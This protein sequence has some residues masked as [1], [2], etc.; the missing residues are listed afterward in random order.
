MGSFGFPGELAT[1]IDAVPGLADELWQ[2]GDV[3]GTAGFLDAVQGAVDDGR[4]ALVVGHHIAVWNRLKEETPAYLL[5]YE[6]FAQ[7]HV[8]LWAE[9]GLEPPNR[10]AF[11]GFEGFDLE[12]PARSAK[13]GRNALCPCGSGQKYKRC[14]GASA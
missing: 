7:E 14:C 12:L 10:E 4:L 13:I 9:A 8:G 1:Y 5:E 11:T 6:A 2:A 3:G